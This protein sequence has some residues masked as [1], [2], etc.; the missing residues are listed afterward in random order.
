MFSCWLLKFN[1]QCLKIKQFKCHKNTIKQR[2]NNCQWCLYGIH[3]MRLV[4]HIPL[5]GLDRLLQLPEVVAPRISRQSAH[6]GEMVVSSAHGLPLPPRRHP[7][8]SFLLE[9]ESTPGSE[10][11]QGLSQWKIPITPSVINPAT[12]WLVM[13]CFN[14]LHHHI[15]SVKNLNFT[16]F[17]H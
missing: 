3:S 12:F 17:A 10:C 9:A 6:E 14:Q 1:C 11:S 8:Y 7:W 13:Q 2:V 16:N 5:I 4:K 15:S